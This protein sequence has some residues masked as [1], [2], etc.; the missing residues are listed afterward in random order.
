MPHRESLAD[1]TDPEAA[2]M[3]V[4]VG[5]APDSWGVWFA[6]DP[7]QMPWQRYL[8]E[9]VLIRDVGIPGYLRATTGLSD[10]NDVLLDASARLAATELV[11]APSSAIGAP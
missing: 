6:D 11:A 1:L 5:S 8:D 10:E 3:D 9:G 4:K 7:K 2:S